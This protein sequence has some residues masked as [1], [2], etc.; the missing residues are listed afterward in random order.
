MDFQA[1]FVFSPFSASFVPDETEGLQQTYHHINDFKPLNN[2]LCQLSPPVPVRI[3][4]EEV[5]GQ[6]N[7]FLLLRYFTL[8][9]K[10]VLKM[11][12][13]TGAKVWQR[14][15]QMYKM[16]MGLQLQLG[17]G[18]SEWEWTVLCGRRCLRF[19]V[20]QPG[21]F[22]CE[23]RWTAAQLLGGRKLQRRL[24][25]CWWETEQKQHLMAYCTL[26]VTTWYFQN[27]QEQGENWEMACSSEWIDFCCWE[28]REAERQRWAQTNTTA[29][30]S[31]ERCEAA[32]CTDRGG[33]RIHENL[34]EP[35]PQIICQLEIKHLMFI[36]F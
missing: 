16:I 14:F 7:L 21:V 10:A 1:V 13:V 15:N 9:K 5:H 17:A 35:E 11:T 12:E 27:K 3:K 20:Q 22:R 26:P 4:G 6:L 19:E 33:W 32:G 36:W 29:A 8:M 23:T 24:T 2:S 18:T 28:T 34:L 31:V 30:I 25:P